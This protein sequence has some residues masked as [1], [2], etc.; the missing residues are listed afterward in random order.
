MVTQDPSQ[1]PSQRVRLLAEHG[2]AITVDHA[3]P[4]RRYF[5]SGQEM[6]RMANVYYEENN[7]ESAF[8]LYSKYMTIFVEKLPKHP[9]YKASRPEDL[10]NAKKNVKSAFPKAEDT[11][12]K[13]QEKY[14]E[15]FKIWQAQEEQRRAEEAQRQAEEARRLE[16]ERSRREAEEI[17]RAEEEKQRLEAQNR[18]AVDEQQRELDEQKAALYQAKMAQEARDREMA[19]RMKAAEIRQEQERQAEAQRRIAG[20]VVP[21]AVAAGAAMATGPASAGGL[22]PPPSYDAVSQGYG[23]K[24]PSH[25]L[26][27]APPPQPS[28]VN[29]PVPTVDR[30]LKVDRST[31][32][33]GMLGIASTTANKYGLR[34]LF[35]PENTMQKF[36]TLA[37]NNTVR[38]LETC[39]ILAGSLARNA[40]TI[41]HIIVPKQTSTSDSC[42]ALNEED[43]FDF[44]DNNALITLGWIHTHP[45]QTAF[46]SSV[47]LHTHCP[48]QLMMPEAIAI[49]C[50]PSHN[51]TGFFS[52][53][54]DH[55]LNFIAKCTLKGFHPHPSHPPIYEE[56]AH[57]KLSNNIPSIKIADLR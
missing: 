18:N 10:K 53:T 38:N 28:P 13:L 47:D 34:D 6:I 31:K 41:T 25:V 8:V 30:S 43:I 42:T 24:P 49:V 48:Y 27:S 46:M 37:N 15:E 22:P 12:K 39:G 23:I 44:V 3:V 5:R 54:P 19:E 32:P 26:P 35:I 50:A 21:P 9:G 51:E 16:E 1:E 14:A 57:C 52:L 17:A 7:W 36:L 45:T 2:S 33:S 4:I 29:T 56:G 11:K 55:G 20:A 40:F